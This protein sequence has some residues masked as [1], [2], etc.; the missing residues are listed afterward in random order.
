MSYANHESQRGHCC[1]QCMCVCVSANKNKSN[2][3]MTFGQ[4]G[5]G[6]YAGKFSLFS[7]HSER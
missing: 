2:I 5:G 3:L 7:P 6:G 4:G 1:N